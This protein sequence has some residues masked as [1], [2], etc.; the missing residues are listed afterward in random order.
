M[1]WFINNTRIWRDLHKMYCISTILLDCIVYYR[2][3]KCDRAYFSNAPLRLNWRSLALC[4]W[5]EVADTASF[6]E[7]RVHAAVRPRVARGIV[8]RLTGKYGHD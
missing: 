1:P 2:Q 3:L 8:I 7:S 6:T 4:E 5:N